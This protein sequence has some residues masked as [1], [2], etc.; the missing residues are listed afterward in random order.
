MALRH[1]CRFTILCLFASMASGFL[2]YTRWTKGSPL[3]GRFRSILKSRKGTGMMPD[4][5]YS[6]TESKEEIEVRMKVPESTKV[7]E[8][9][10]SLGARSVD[11]TCNNKVLLRGEFRRKV[12]VDSCCWNFDKRLESNEEEDDH[13]DETYKDVVLRLVKKF[14]LPHIEEEWCGVLDDVSEMNATKEYYFHERDKFDM[15]RYLAYMGGFNE[16]YTHPRSHHCYIYIIIIS[17]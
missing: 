3:S 8:I 6:W 9:H 14:K 1:I 10:Y 15:K 7:S 11:L 5:S 4:R 13:N 17:F 12:S 16:R 2:Q